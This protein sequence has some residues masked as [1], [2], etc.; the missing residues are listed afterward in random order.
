MGWWRRRH[1]RGW[2]PSAPPPPAA[3][4]GKG[5]RAGKAF[6]SATVR[7]RERSLA[8]SAAL[9]A[10][11]GA[12]QKPPLSTA[13]CRAGGGCGRLGLCPKDLRRR[14]TA[15]LPAAVF[16]LAMSGTG[17][18]PPYCQTEISQTK[19]S[20]IFRPTLNSTASSTVE[21]TLGI[22][23]RS[24]ARPFCCFGLDLYGKVHVDGSMFQSQWR[25]A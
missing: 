21:L 25:V 1:G 14:G 17:I 24:S 2:Q 7:A 13:F 5:R 4:A 3:R 18:A 16:P 11:C 6:A 9:R 22:N 23:R 19:F 8:R 15:S 20:Q 10:A 12:P